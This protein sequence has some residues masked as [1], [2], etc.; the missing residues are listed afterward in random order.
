MTSVVAPGD[1]F[2]RTGVVVY[3]LPVISKNGGRQSLGYTE[4]THTKKIVEK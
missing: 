2:D 1:G 3:P 4:Q